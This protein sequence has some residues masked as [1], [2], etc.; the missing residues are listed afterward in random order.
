MPVSVASGTHGTRRRAKALYCTELP[1]I[2]VDLSLYTCTS[3][4]FDWDFCR[5]TGSLES[6]PLWFPI[7]DR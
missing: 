5:V 4:V 7:F 2:T 3:K 1:N 6:F